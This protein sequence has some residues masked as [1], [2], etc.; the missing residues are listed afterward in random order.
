M[1]D[2][3]KIRIVKGDIIKQEVD[4]IVNAANNGLLGGSGVDGAIHAAGGRKILEECKAI[5]SKI[6]SLKTGEAVITSGGNLKAKYV[7]HT[8]GPIWRGGNSN[9][10]IFLTNAY[11][12]SLK[13]AAEQGIK[14]IAFP[15]I[16][17][18]VYGYPKEQA[19]KVAFSTV[20][21]S[22]NTYKEID[23]VRFICFDEETYNL[24]IALLIATV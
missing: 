6:G 7:I 8:V 10:E 5:I 4:A 11:K 24:Y 17:A 23:E 1:L 18:G 22:L 3:D 12:N 9:E 14:T 15:C 2:R 19:A 13:L 16:S 21:Q 20:L